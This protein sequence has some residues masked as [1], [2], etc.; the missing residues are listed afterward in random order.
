MGA[1]S[2]LILLFIIFG[3]PVILLYSAL[4]LFVRGIRNRKPAR[5]VVA[6]LLACLAVAYPLG[7]LR[8]ATGAHEEA[9]KA[10][11]QSQMK[12]IGLAL[13]MYMDENF[14]TLPS[15]AVGGCS[16]EVFRKTLGKSLTVKHPKTVFQFLHPYLRYDQVFHCPSDPDYDHPSYVLKKAINDAWLDPKIKARTETD[17]NWPDRQMMFYER[18]SF[19]WGDTYGDLSDP[20]NPKK[21]DATASFYFMDGHVKAMRLTEFE[22]DYYNTD[23][24]SDKPATRPQ[25]NPLLYRDTLE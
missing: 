19:H 25:T 5:C 15:S 6:T 9:R 10:T 8:L 21:L 2:G 4:I 14:D 18:G 12:E 23:G 1:V 20:K 3:I 7:I 24:T 13:R 22:P 11:C 17:F 16:D